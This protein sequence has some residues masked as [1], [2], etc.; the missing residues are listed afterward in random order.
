LHKVQRGELAAVQV[1]QRRR[2]AADCMTNDDGEEAV[3]KQGLEVLA[4]LRSR[5]RGEAEPR[6]KQ[7]NRRPVDRAL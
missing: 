7:T 1:T 6:E 5:G 4:E 2:E 3:V